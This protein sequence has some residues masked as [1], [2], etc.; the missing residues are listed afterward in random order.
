MTHWIIFLSSYN[1]DC[2]HFPSPHNPQHSLG[3][4]YS[5]SMTT[6]N[7]LPLF[8]LSGNKGSHWPQWKLYPCS[9]TWYVLKAPLPPAAPSPSSFASS[10]LCC[11]L[12]LSFSPIAA[13]IFEISDSGPK[14]P[15]TA[16]PL[17]L[18]ASWLGTG[19]EGGRK[20]GRDIQYPSHFP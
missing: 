20:E 12:V 5:S 1:I 15:I 10:H 9:P 18:A 8:I 16:H 6:G 11:S 19:Q 4:A 3:E 13:K 2:H 7:C 17:D 14:L